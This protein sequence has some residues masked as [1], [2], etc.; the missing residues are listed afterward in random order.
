M[1]HKRPKISGTPSLTTK[2]MSIMIWGK[3]VYFSMFLT[4]SCREIK[5]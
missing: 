1:F 4:Q 5:W 2:Y 3:Y